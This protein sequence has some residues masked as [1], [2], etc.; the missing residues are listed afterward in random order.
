[1]AMSSGRTASRRAGRRVRDVARCQRPAAGLEV[2]R[3]KPP[4]QTGRLR[5][6]PAPA[7][8]LPGGSWRG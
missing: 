8:L 2:P 6:L 4:I 1:M 3:A 5:S 7:R